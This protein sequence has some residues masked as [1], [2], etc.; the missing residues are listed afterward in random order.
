M[1]EE[2]TPNT[3]PIDDADRLTA[4]AR[5]RDLLSTGE[6]AVEPFS[7]ALD[8]VLGAESHAALE[9][10]MAPLPSIVRLTPA[11]RRLA[12]PLVINAGINSLELGAGWQLAA[13]TSV[14]TVTGRCRLDLTQA[15]WDTREVDLR[16]ESSTGEIEVIVPEGVSVQLVSV[17]GRV[18]LNPL[19]PPL[20]GGPLLRVTASATMGRIRIHSPIPARRRGLRR[21]RRPSE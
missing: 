17:R 19:A 15:T 1:T 10:A 12:H 8:R 16:L 4:I 7:A 11:S 2:P 21:R 5:L 3:D 20:P 14:T 9:S 13:D 6:L 18:T